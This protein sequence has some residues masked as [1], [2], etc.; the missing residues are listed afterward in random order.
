MSQINYETMT[1]EE[2]KQYILSHRDDRAAFHAYLDRRHARPNQT[3][4]IPGE[5]R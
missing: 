1:D 2:L 5:S 3:V 4:I